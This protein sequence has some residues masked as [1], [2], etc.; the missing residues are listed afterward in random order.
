[1]IRGADTL[2]LTEIALARRELAEK[3]SEGRLSLDEVTGG[4][5]TLTNL[6]ML[7]VDVFQ[8][9]INPPQSA[10]LATGRIAERPVVEDG[11]V[12]ASPT[13]Y[14]TLSVD[15]RVLDGATAARFLQDLQVHIEDPDEFFLRES[16]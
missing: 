14:L 13:V 7:G 8:A 4:T 1:V 5:F 16:V 10:I 15:H 2:S 11:Q 12:V 9:I 3:A 6:G